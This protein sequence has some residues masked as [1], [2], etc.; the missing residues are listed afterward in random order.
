MSATIDLDAY[1]RRIGHDGPAA[2]DLETLRVLHLRH[3]QAIAFENLDPLTGQA[4]HLGPAALER[5]LVHARRGGYCF[6]H[7]TLF[8]HVLSSLGFTVDALV[9]CTLWQQPPGRPTARGHMALMV[10]IDGEAYLADVGFGALTLTTPLR[11]QAGPAQATPH[12]RFR[13]LP[14]GAGFRLEA[15]VAGDWQPLYRFDTAPFSELDIAFAN[16]YLS[17][18]PDSPFAR[19]LLA[20]RVNSELRYALRNNRLS[21][22]RADGTSEHELLDSPEAL[23]RVLQETFALDLPDGPALDAALARVSRALAANRPADVTLRPGVPDDDDACGRIISAATLAAPTAD[24]L[25]HA[26]ALFEDASPL[27]AK[28]GGR[29]VGVDAGGRVLGFV[30]FDAARAYLHYLFVA[31]EAQG[32]GLGTALLEA[33]QAACGGRAVTLSCWSVNDRALDWYLR[34]GFRVVGGGFKE[35]AGRPVVRLV[36][37]RPAG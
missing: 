14:D 27:P 26:R 32:R 15:E 18:H 37:S 21:V 22:H 6:E 5:K 13:L 20:A 3:P 16:H 10:E 19:E 9:G 29:L 7:N 23:R 8:R 28:G 30:D 31:P 25:P 12:G 17:S 1:F 33:A 4:V 36:L 2:A 24:R 34:R 35:L 11:L